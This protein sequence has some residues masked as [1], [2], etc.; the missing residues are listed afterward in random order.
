MEEKVEPT[1]LWINYALHNARKWLGFWTKWNPAT[2]EVFECFDSIRDIQLSE[3]KTKMKHQNTFM[4]KDGRVLNEGPMNGPWEYKIDRDCDEE[5]LCHPST[6]FQAKKARAFFFENGG[7]VW[8]VM[9]PSLGDVFF[10]EMFFPKADI[11]LSTGVSFDK[12]GKVMRLAAIREDS[13]CRPSLYWSPDTKISEAFNAPVQG[14][15]I[16][17]ERILTAGLKQTVKTDCEWD[18]NYWL[19]E[20]RRK[21]EGNTVLYLPDNIALSYP[22]Q[23]HQTTTSQH[24]HISTFCFYDDDKEKVEIREQAVHYEN[25]RFSYIKQGIYHKVCNPEHTQL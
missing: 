18:R 12:D 20:T 1:K 11:R 15:F 25:G 2:C 8:T 9:E 4:Y 16:G 23:L 19:T 5:G 17:T 7:G 21:E 14:K 6:R 13:R 24:F 3:D 22:L 10:Q